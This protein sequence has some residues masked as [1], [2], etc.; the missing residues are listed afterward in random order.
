MCSKKYNRERTLLTVL[1]DGRFHSGESL[2]ETLGVT[3][4]AIWKMIKLLEKRGIDIQSVNGKGYRIPNGLCF[5]DETT[6]QSHLHP[7]TR[8][9]LHQLDCFDTIESTNDYLLEQARRHSQA[10]T[11]AC[12]AEQQTGGKGRRGREWVSPYA[13]NIYHS[14]L[15]YFNHDPSELIGLSLAVA[16]CVARALKAIGITNGLELK[17]PN[18]LLWRGRKLCGI[19]IEMYAEPHQ[20]CALVIGIGINTRLTTQQQLDRPIASTEDILN[21]P[22]DRNVLAA[23][24]LNE[25]IPALTEF[26][27]TGLKSFLNEWRSMD[28]FAG[29]MIRLMSPRQEITGLVKGISERGELL[30]EDTQGR[31]TSYLSGEVSI[32]LTE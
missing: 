13:N 20:Q 28:S 26:Q 25:I 21:K 8:Q 30:L 5:L 11:I 15:W 16:V 1:S 7:E 10:K 31:V 2:G 4:S 32:K 23:N 22:T 3:R 27:Q 9:Q 29:R 12:F 24:L 18:D 19:L 17:W 14:L 6:I